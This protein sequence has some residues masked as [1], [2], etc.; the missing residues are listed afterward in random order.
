MM[1][2]GLQQAEYFDITQAGEYIGIVKSIKG[3]TDPVA[4]LRRQQQRI[5]LMVHR[6]TIPYIKIGSRLYFEKAALDAWMRSGAH[7]PCLPV[8]RPRLVRRRP[9][10]PSSEK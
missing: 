8:H 7:Q 3:D 5:Y 1:Q 9:S 6:G 10:K 2:P 4:T